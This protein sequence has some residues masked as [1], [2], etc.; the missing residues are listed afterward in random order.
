MFGQANKISLCPTLSLTG[1]AGIPKPDEPI[2]FTAN[3][4]NEA[5]KYNLKYKWTVSGGEIIEG[6]GTST[7]KVL[8]KELGGNLTVT[9]EIIGLPKDCANTASETAGTDCSFPIPKLIDEFTDSIAQ[10]DKTRFDKI[11]T[12]VKGDPTTQLYVLAWHFKNSPQETVKRKEQDIFDSLTAAGIEKD[13]ITLV[14]DFAERESIQFW[15]VPAGATP[16]T[17]N[18]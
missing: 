3:L 5:E 17:L 14:F 1:P 9:I 13:R 18:Q 8:Q 6:Q 2:S 7:S 10:K 16:P 15:I 11:A 4:S 12:D